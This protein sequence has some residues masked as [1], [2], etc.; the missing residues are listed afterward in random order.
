MPRGYEKV[1]PTRTRAAG[2]RDIEA[3]AFDGAP[4]AGKKK[5][6]KKTAKQPGA[7]H[8]FP[9]G[10]RIDEPSCLTCTCDATKC[11]ICVIGLGL[12][13]LIIAGATGANDASGIAKSMSSAAQRT[14]SHNTLPPR[15]P[16]ADTDWDA[17][18]L[19]LN[20]PPPNPPPPPTPPPPSSSPPPSP[21]PSLP[22]SPSPL[23]PSPFSPH[24][25]QSPKAPPPQ[26]PYN[27]IISR[28][29]ARFEFAQP[30]NDLDI[31]G[32]LVHTFD[33]ISNGYEPWAPCKSGGCAAKFSDRFP[34]SIIYDGITNMYKGTS[35]GFVIAPAAAHVL[36]SY[37]RDGLTMRGEKQC[38]I[39]TPSNCIPGCGWSPYEWCPEAKPWRCAWPPNRLDDMLAAHKRDNPGDHN[40]VVLGASQWEEH[41]PSTVEAVWFFQQGTLTPALERA[42]ANAEDIHRRFLRRYALTAA[43]VPLVS[44]DPARMPPFACDRCGGFATVMSASTRNDVYRS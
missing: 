16:P 44:F 4:T 15:P 11:G 8:R 42:K 40:E 13:A 12:A 2:A 38:P 1:S 31:A 22:P 33:E 19:A 41:L 24:P 6:K 5:R 20:T 18:M 3:V 39:P 9:G 23:S 17:A 10:Q 35:G 25:P 7:H 30:S 29:N 34:C 36:C 32:V 27:A 26:P 37:S 43:D 14:R 28:I 21:N